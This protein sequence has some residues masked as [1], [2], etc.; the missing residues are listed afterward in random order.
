MQPTNSFI[1]ANSPCVLIEGPTW[2]DAEFYAKW[3]LAAA[4]AETFWKEARKDPD[5]KKQVESVCTLSIPDFGIT[6][7][8]IVMG[9]EEYRTTLVL[10]LCNED[11]EDFV[12][13]VMMGFFAPTNQ[14]YRMAIPFDLT[15]AKVK[16]AI[17]RYAETMDE[18]YMLYPEYLVDTVLFPEARA[19]QNR[20]RAIY[21]FR[22]GSDVSG[23]A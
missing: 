9:L 15:A 16:K 21:Q 2:G 23:H 13:M 3:L 10:D 7:S 17:V 18:E 4:Q 8:V 1:S 5:F 22:D 12:M 14:G 19:R 20:L 11:G 6:A